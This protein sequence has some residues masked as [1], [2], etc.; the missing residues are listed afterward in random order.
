VA[1]KPCVK[2]RGEGEPSRIK[3]PPLELIDTIDFS[4]TPPY[5]QPGFL[6]Q[7][8]VKE[9]LSIGQIAAKI[10]SSKEAVRKGL[11][12]AG[13]PIREPHKPHGHPSRPRYGQKIRKG[14]EEPHRYEQ[15]IIEA[16]IDMRAKGLSLRE[17]A[18]ILTQMKIPT[19]ERGKGWHPE[20]VKRIIVPRFSN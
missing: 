17:I 10:P 1:G 5:R 2:W 8:Y 6:H 19:K 13:I 12:R 18:K 3:F 7:K 16:I 15:H 20:M 14:K 11:I 9:G 4:H